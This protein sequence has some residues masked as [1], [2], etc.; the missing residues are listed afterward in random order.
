[1]TEYVTSALFVYTDET[2]HLVDPLQNNSLG[3]P[4]TS[5]AFDALMQ[6]PQQQLEGAGHVVV[7]GPIDVLK[8]ILRL[9]V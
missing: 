8:E 7:A 2:N 6:A 1:M 3:T 4:I 5:V 9:D